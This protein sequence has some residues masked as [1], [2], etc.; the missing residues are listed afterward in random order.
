MFG[1]P[2]HATFSESVEGKTTI[3]TKTHSLVAKT[4]IVS[5]NVFHR[6]NPSHVEVQT[7][8]PFLRVWS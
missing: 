8:R 4:N 1:L 5:G 3:Y 2:I 6:A 7:L